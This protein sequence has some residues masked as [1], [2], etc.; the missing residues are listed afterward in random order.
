MAS[1]IL[2]KYRSDLANAITDP[3]SIAI[4]LFSRGVISHHDMTRVTS[5]DDVPVQTELL[6][7][8]ME[9]EAKKNKDSFHEFL[10]VLKKAGLEKVSSSMELD[11]RS[12]C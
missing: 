9:F 4:E 2:S 8:L 7:N 5:E 11:L 1:S 3:D 6:L 10:H 12:S